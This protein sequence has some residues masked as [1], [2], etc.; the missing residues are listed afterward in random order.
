MSVLHQALNELGVAGEFQEYS[1]EQIAGVVTYVADAPELTKFEGGKFSLHKKDKY[2]I[3][4]KNDQ[5]VGWLTLGDT[6]YLGQQ[7]YSF[8]LIYIMPQYRNT[9]A[10]L[11]L[12]YGVKELLDKPIIVDGMLFVKGRELLNAVYTRDRYKISTVDKKTGERTRY[13]P[14]DLVVDKD[15]NFV[16]IESTGMGLHFDDQLPGQNP[17]K[18]YF[19]LFERLHDIEKYE[20]IH[21]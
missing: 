17:Y 2:Y 8:D 20:H 19:S 16:I 4:K 18:M 11:L 14:S 10:T 5:L 1:P 7:Y 13:R 21:S 3:L 9:R 15:K 12:V 6:T